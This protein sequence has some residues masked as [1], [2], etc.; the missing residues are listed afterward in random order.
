MHAAVVQVSLAPPPD[1]SGAG[2]YAPRVRRK[3]DDS[4]QQR[5]FLCFP[6]LDSSY[7]IHIIALPDRTTT[8]KHWDLTAYVHSRSCLRVNNAIFDQNLCILLGE[9]ETC[10]SNITL[11]HTESEF[12]YLLE[13]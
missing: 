1:S 12:A 5:A 10:V 13:K 4:T 2:R 8:S 3:A 11:H 7:F 6:D 9:H